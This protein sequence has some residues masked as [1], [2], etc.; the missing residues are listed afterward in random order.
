MNKKNLFIRN[1]KK[2]VKEPTIGT[3]TVAITDRRANVATSAGSEGEDHYQNVMIISWDVM[4]ISCDGFLS[5]SVFCLV[6][7]LPSPAGFVPGRH[8]K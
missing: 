4:V 8:S 3:A 7:P 5:V 1:N 6:V 2:P